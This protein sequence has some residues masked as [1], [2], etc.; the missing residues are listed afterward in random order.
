MLSII[1][2]NCQGASDVRFPSVFK[3]LVSNYRSDVFVLLEPRISGAKADKVIKKLLFRHS[4]RVEADGFAG[5]F[6][7]KLIQHI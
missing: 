3:S 5:V 7:G 6:P 1:S 2:W 4:H